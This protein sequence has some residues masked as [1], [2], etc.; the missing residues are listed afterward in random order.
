VASI[1]GTK[2]HKLFEYSVENRPLDIAK[3]RALEAS[4]KEYG[5]LPCYPIVC[6]RDEQRKLVV[7]DGQHRLAVA[8]KLGL[9]V[10]YVVTNEDYDVAKVN[11]GQKTWITGDYAQCFAAQNVKSYEECIEFAGTYSVTIGMAAMML[12]GTVSFGNI[13]AEFHSGKFKV[14]DRNFAARVASVFT[15]ITGLNKRL[16]NSLFLQA[17]MAV[18]RVSDVDIQR[19]VST[20]SRCPEKLMPYASRDALLQMLQDIYNFGHSKN[21]PLKFEAEETM[22]SRNP[23]EKAKRKA[24]QAK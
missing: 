8:A 4:M 24:K 7:K 9:P 3:H 18:C 23:K 22:K 2:N 11:A 17:C 21:R 5:F 6:F 13:R 15:G 20:A 14:R 10:F 12:S 19:L 1:V 16:R